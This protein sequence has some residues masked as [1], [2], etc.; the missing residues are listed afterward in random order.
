MD[1]RFGTLD[2]EVVKM[3]NEKGVELVEVK[4]LKVFD[5]PHEM[6]V[7]D[8]AWNNEKLVKKCVCAILPYRHAGSVI[9]TNGAYEHCAEIPEDK[10]PRRA[11]WLELS[12]WISKGD[13]LVLDELINR[14]DTGI[15]F[16]VDNQN[17]PVDDKI[18]VRKW[19]DKEWHTPD[20]EYL[21]IKE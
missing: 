7:W 14:I 18:K 5:E 17:A 8:D 12:K 9:T 13:G 2:R 1:S 3:K 20:V 19:D 16:K 15:M 11:T 6:Y 21:G 4:E 10:T